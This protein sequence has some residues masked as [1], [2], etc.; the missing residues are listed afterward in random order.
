MI[1]E[2]I[3]HMI[4][5]T[6]FTLKRIFHPIKKKLVKTQ[7]LDDMKVRVHGGG[8]RRQAGLS[9]AGARV[10]ELALFGGGVCVVSFSRLWGGVEGER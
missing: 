9:S 7:Q 3:T 8:G 10:G 5:Q 6:T 1:G 4:G 2:N